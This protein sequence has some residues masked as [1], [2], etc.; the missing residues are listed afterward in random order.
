MTA[1]ISVS[2]MYC[3]PWMPKRPFGFVIL[4][5][6]SV[7]FSDDADKFFHFSPVLASVRL[8]PGADVNRIGMQ[9]QNR[10]P[11]VLRVQPAGKEVRPPNLPNKFPVKRPARGLRRNPKAHSRAELA[12]ARRQSGAEWMRNA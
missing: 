7:R 11:D 4:F 2:G 8:N 3:P 9:A 10:A 6:S 12:A 1:F 5:T